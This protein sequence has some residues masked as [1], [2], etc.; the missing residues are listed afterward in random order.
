MHLLRTRKGDLGTPSSESLSRCWWRFYRWC[1]WSPLPART[2]SPHWWEASVALAG[3]TTRLELAGLRAEHLFYQKIQALTA[4]ANSQG[5]DLGISHD[6]LAN[7]SRQEPCVFPPV[8]SA[9]SW[10]VVAWHW[11]AVP[12]G[13]DRDWSRAAW[14]LLKWGVS[15][16]GLYHLK[17]SAF[18]KIM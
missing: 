4:P 2:S 17:M 3:S 18:K 10:C 13:V 1:I 14:C 16:K 11:P 12:S 7:N 15:L 5:R 9:P 6:S 8:F